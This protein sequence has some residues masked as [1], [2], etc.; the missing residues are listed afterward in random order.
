M[1]A[2]VLAESVCIAATHP[3]LPGHFPG[4]PIVPGVVLLDRV[5]ALLERA[6]AG[7]LA[8]ID[9]VKFAAPLRPGQRASLNVRVDGARASFRIERDGAPVLVGEAAL[10]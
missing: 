9:V 2:G 10:A 3:G 7:R 6:G 5:A 1:S 8:R 4:D